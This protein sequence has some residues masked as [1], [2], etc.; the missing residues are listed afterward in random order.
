[1]SALSDTI[2]IGGRCGRPD[3]QVD[4]AATGRGRRRLARPQAAQRA[5]AT[6]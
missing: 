5:D 4:N 3:M 1:M 6:T 2:V